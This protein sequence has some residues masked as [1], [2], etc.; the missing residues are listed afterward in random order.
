MTDHFPTAEATSVRPAYAIVEGG[1]GAHLL[2]TGD[3]IALS[4]G[5]LVDKLAADAHGRSIRSVDL[6]DLG[7]IDSAG[8]LALLD[9][10]PDLAVWQDIG[11]DDVDRL[12]QLVEPTDHP[13]PDRPNSVPGFFVKIGM[14]VENTAREAFRNLEFFGQLIF[15]FGRALAHPRRLR[16]TS[17]F[18]MMEAVGISAIPI[19]MTM[20]FFIGAVIALVGA[21]LLTTLGVAVFAVQ[22]VGVAVL[23]EFGVVIASILLAG[24]SASA[25]AAA[26]GSMR[27]NQEVDA[28]Q[29]LGVDRFDAL[30]VPRV[31]AAL[32]M[33][34]LMTFCAD[35]GGIVGGQ[36]VSW[37]TMGISPVFFYNRLV[38][39]VSVSHFWIG[40]SKTPLLALIVSSTGCRHGLN[41][42][43][44]TESLGRQVTEAVVQSIFL[45][46]LVDAIF[47]V[48]FMVLHL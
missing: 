10:I 4:L 23:R 34:P 18:A 39:T 30:V 45:I 1:E 37:A 21:N 26:L 36:L 48:S 9:A 14:A 40:I 25:F 16:L 41:V 6:K 2:L 17:L 11:R 35:I 47:A 38:D 29:V 12:A 33:L 20:T 44:S 13:A 5:A 3:W 43:G 27:M 32:L 22:L 31:L 28:M 42:G 46:I 19:V 8:A 24:R 7:R 15:S